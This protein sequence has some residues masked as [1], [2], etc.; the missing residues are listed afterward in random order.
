VGLGRAGAMSLEKVHY[1]DTRALGFFIATNKAFSFM[2]LLPN[3][4]PL[5]VDL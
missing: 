3:E 5:D 2:I 4:D 1:D